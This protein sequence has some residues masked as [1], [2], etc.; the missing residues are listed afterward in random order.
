[1]AR[2][3]TYEL[4]GKVYEGKDAKRRGA[5]IT[6]ANTVAMFARS[7]GARSV[8][9]VVAT[10]Q[11]ESGFAANEVDY[12]EPDE[13]GHVFVSKGLYQISDAEAQKVG[14][15]GVNLLDPLMATRVF[16]RLL[17]HN[18]D[19]LL[20]S[21][22]PMLRAQLATS[23]DIWAYLALAHNEGLGRFAATDARGRH[24]GAL[25]TIYNYGIDWRAYELRNV[26]RGICQYGRDCIDGGPHWQHV[27]ASLR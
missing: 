20:A 27:S 12:E 23:E 11:H 14:F 5:L 21:L 19:A 26:G 9:H 18:R 22:P 2:R 15:S 7:L 24:A 6:D 25:T 10:A 1:M 3:T 17:E 16:V 4:N 8:K 13:D